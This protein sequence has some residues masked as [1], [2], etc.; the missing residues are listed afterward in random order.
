MIVHHAQCEG[1][2]YRTFQEIV[3]DCWYDKNM[4]MKNYEGKISMVIASFS[5]NPQKSVSSSSNIP[6]NESAQKILSL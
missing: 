1:K 5:Q 6:S 3:A 2:D 4:T